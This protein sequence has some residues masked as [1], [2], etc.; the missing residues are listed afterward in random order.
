[1]AVVVKQNT[2]E[3]NTLSTE[4][5]FPSAPFPRKYIHMAFHTY[6]GAMQASIVLISSGSDMRDIHLMTGRDFIEAVEQRLTPI[7]FFCSSD[8]H[9][10]MRE[11]KR[12]KY[13]LSVRFSSYEQM[14][15]VRDLLAPYGA[16]SM[17]YVDTWSVTPLIV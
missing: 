2:L 14:N 17:A 6:Q 11:A 15:Q 12:G 3:Q 9:I 7:G 13:M 5:A 16:Y 4:K 8:D 10:Y 1:M